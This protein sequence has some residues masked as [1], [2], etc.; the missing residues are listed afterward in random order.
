M[1]SVFCVSVLCVCVCVVCACVVCVCVVCVCVVCVCVVCVLCVC[2][3]C[4]CVVLRKSQTDFYTAG[5]WSILGR[6]QTS[7]SSYCTV[8]VLEPETTIPQ[9]CILDEF[10]CPQWW[11]SSVSFLHLLS[12]QLCQWSTSVLRPAHL[13]RRLH[14]LRLKGVVHPSTD[15]CLYIGQTLCTV[16]TCIHDQSYVS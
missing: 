1:S 11:T 2:G 12:A 16:T 14:Q 6:F 8:Q 13:L 3:V 9:G 7:E 10:D 15:L 4:V 5:N